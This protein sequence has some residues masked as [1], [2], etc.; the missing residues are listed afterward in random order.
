VLADSDAETVSEEDT[1]LE[2]CRKIAQWDDVCASPLRIGHP[3]QGQEIL[4]Y[5]DGVNSTTILGELFGQRNP[6][7]FVRI[8]LREPVAMDQGP[9][10]DIENANMDF[11]QRRG[12]FLLPPRSTRYAPFMTVS[13][14]ARFC[15]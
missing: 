13:A 3:A 7:R 1:Q 15:D 6:R 9:K 14:L 11:L 2:T 8:L 5:H 4:E 12:A 10:K